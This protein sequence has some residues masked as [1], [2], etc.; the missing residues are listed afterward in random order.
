M[1][2]CVVGLWHLG[3]VM[4]ASLASVGHSVTALDFDTE[5]IDNLRQGQ[6]PIFEP[7]L[8]ALVRQG[9]DR[10][11]LRFTSDAKSIADADLIWIGYDTPVD[12]ADRADTAYVVERIT[13][14][15]P[16]LKAGALV[17]ISAQLP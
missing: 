6:P 10:G 9:L 11:T 13:R 1:K 7:G 14:L 15:F 12:E 17:L 5:T 8:E 2:I 3:T 4:A 16:H